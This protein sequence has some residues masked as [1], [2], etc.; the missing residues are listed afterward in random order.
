[1]QNQ[2]KSEYLPSLFGI[3]KT[4]FEYDLDNNLMRFEVRNA[5]F[6]AIGKINKFFSYKAEIDL[7]DEGRIRMLDAYVKFT[8]V[9]D[10]DLYMGQRKIPFSTD[11]LRNPAELFF[12]NRS[13]AAKYLNEGMRDIGFIANYKTSGAVPFNF[14]LGAVNGTGNNNPK[15]VEK[16][17]VVG[18]VCAGKDD[19]LRVTGNFYFGEINSLNHVKMYGG[20]VR[21]VVNRFFIESEY[22][23]RTWTDTLALLSREDGMYIH[24]LYHFNLKSNM[25]K[26]LSPTARWDLMGS[27]I[28]KGDI[29]A[30]RLTMG[31]NA[32][33]EIQPFYAEIRLNYENY[34]KG[35]LPIHTDKVTLEFI[36][37]F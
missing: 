21:Y 5:R 25:L 34:I 19:G 23:S 24:S 11:Y 18:R 7:S 17:S 8:P 31:L 35:N 36:G 10:L 32:G 20:E 26:L 6:G 33:F 14:F 13:F 12:A 29:E 30:T 15:W 37:R 16:P 27:S 9:P 22:I 2:E 1:V 4:K 3:L 28:F